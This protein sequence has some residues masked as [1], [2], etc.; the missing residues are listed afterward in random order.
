MRQRAPLEVTGSRLPSGSGAGEEYL[1]S[2]SSEIR[3]SLYTRYFSRS[4]R[5]FRRTMFL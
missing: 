4:N 1:V 2:P 5:P 3:L